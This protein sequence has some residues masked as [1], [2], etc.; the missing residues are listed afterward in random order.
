VRA[1]TERPREFDIRAIRKSQNQILRLAVECKNIG[2]HCPLLVSRIPRTEAEA[3]QQVVLSLNKSRLRIGDET[4]LSLAIHQRAI[5]IDLSGERMPYQPGDFV[6][7]SCDQI[8]LTSGDDLVGNDA[9]VFAK[10][11]QAISSGRDL[12]MQAMGDGADADPAAIVL[13]VP[14]V[15]IPNGRL[16]VVDYSAIGNRI[17]DPR[18]VDRCPYFVGRQMTWKKGMAHERYTFSHLEFVTQTGLSDLIGSLGNFE[19]RYSVA[20]AIADAVK[21]KIPLRQVRSAAD[22]PAFKFPD[23]LDDDD[24]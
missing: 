4:P 7:K 3:F 11:S 1:V 5:T 14:I 8:G 20:D 16:W 6:G 22:M 23:P 19:N 12:A 18:L 15:V 2:A 9:D 13:I 24:I 21:E 17:C 10:W